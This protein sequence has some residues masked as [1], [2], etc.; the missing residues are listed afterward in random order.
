MTAF[1]QVG[2]THLDR[3]KHIWFRDAGRW[4]CCVCGAVTLKTPPTD[5]VPDGW[6]PEAYEPLTEAERGMAPFR[7]AAGARK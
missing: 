6:F 1:Q 7:E 4:R 5:P 3:T 2:E